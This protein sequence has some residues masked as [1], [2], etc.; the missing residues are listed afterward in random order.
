MSETLSKIQNDQPEPRKKLGLNERRKPMAK[1]IK[2]IN[3]AKI[4][5]KLDEENKQ[6]LLENAKTR[7]QI[8]EIFNTYPNYKPE[9]MDKRFKTPPKKNTTTHL[10]MIHV[11]KIV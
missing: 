3:E 6:K 11:S 8:Q 2:I 10:I 7:N 9:N 5:Q 1:R 4:Q